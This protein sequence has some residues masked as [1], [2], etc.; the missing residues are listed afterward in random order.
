VET[1]LGNVITYRADRA[2]FVIMTV[3]LL[4]FSAL[5]IAM[6]VV[7]ITEK[8]F[9]N[10]VIALMLCGLFGWMDFAVIMKALYPPVV[11]ISVDGFSCS[12]RALLQSGTTY[13]WTEI[14]GPTQTFGSGGVPLVQM[15]VNDT[16]KELRFPPSHF[17]ATYDEMAAVIS[18]A[19]DGRII[20]PLDY[21]QSHRKFVVPGW[22]VALVPFAAIAAGVA[23]ALLS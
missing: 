18:G 21:R 19:R 9:S 23:W 3:F 16:G 15:V 17:G 13:R 5:P 8:E 12:N 10:L 7:D 11:K 22:L 6:L 20:D 1:V 4:V 2:R 14:E